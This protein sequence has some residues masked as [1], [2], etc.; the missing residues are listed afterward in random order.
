MFDVASNILPKTNCSNTEVTALSKWRRGKYCYLYCVIKF[1]HWLNQ[2]SRLQLAQWERIICS[3]HHFILK[4][5]YINL[6]QYCA[7]EHVVNM[8][9]YKHPQHLCQTDESRNSYCHQL[10]H[11]EFLFSMS[12]A[13]LATNKTWCACACAEWRMNTNSLFQ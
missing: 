10:N 7:A 3:Q 9:G 1:I 12:E 4:D 13:S 8:C 5:E 11:S 6:K 2:W